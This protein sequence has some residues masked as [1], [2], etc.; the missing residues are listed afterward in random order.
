MAKLLSGNPF[1]ISG[2][3]GDRVYYCSHGRQ[4]VRKSPGP[5]KN[6]PSEVQLGQQAKLTLLSK[7]LKP[8][9]PLL[10][11]TFNKPAA[12]IPGSARAFS[13]NYHRVLTGTYPSLGINYSMLLLSFGN[14]PK[15]ES[16]VAIPTIPGRLRFY[17]TDNSGIC[18]GMTNDKAFIAVYCEEI[19]QWIFMLDTAFRP[20]GTCTVDL[21]EFSTMQVHTYLGFISADG[22]HV[23]ESVYTGMVNV[24]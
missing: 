1:Q 9:K 15:A 18:R 20:N 8:L 2:K 6:A 10:D 13:Q 22:K 12:P 14:L 19:D 23:S 24:I 11:K 16:P 21:K 7:F 5:R 4:M 3:L 17:W